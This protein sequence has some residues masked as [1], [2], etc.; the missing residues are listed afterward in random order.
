MID[1]SIKEIK[2]KIR[3]SYELREK[4]RLE[5]WNYDNDFKKYKK[6][7]TQKYLSLLD[8]EKSEVFE[9]N[10]Q[11]YTQLGS[12]SFSNRSSDKKLKLEVTNIGKKFISL[13]VID[14]VVYKSNGLVSPTLYEVRQLKMSRNNF[15]SLISIDTDMVKYLKREESFNQLI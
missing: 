14:G 15:I 13:K 5:Y 9:L 12:F 4:H 8:L 2:S 3:E 10:I 11:N 7:L 1:K 6:E